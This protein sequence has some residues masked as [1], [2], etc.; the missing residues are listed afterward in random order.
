MIN[1]ILK[2][3][4]FGFFVAFLC[5]RCDQLLTQTP[6]RRSQCSSR[7]ALPFCRNLHAC[8][9]VFASLLNTHA[10]NSHIILTPVQR[11]LSVARF[12]IC[13]APDRPG[14]I[15]ILLSLWCDSAAMRTH[16]FPLSRPT[17]NHLV[18]TRKGLV[19]KTLH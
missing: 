18:V 10:M 3:T 9:R 11:V 6:R 16:N 5:H 12:P 14:A 8:T 17:P 15:T 7:P 13:Q 2:N 1:K 4:A 19:L